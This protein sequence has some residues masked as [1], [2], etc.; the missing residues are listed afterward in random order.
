MQAYME[1]EWPKLYEKVHKTKL[2]T[3]DGRIRLASGDRKPYAEMCARA[4]LLFEHSTGMAD[5]PSLDQKLN[6]AQLISS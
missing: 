4:V 6:E 2:L 1:F 3:D 5:N